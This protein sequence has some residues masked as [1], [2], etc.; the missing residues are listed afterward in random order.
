MRK[1]LLAALLAAACS[2][3]GVAGVAPKDAGPDM[4][5]APGPSPSYPGCIEGPCPP[6]LST[7]PDA[8]VPVCDGGVAKDAGTVKDA[9]RPDLSDRDDDDDDEDYDGRHHHRHHHEK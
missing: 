7:K 8:S 4:V 1:L 3:P 6:D 5:Q 2:D 9:G